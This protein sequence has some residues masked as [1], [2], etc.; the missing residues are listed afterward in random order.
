M[1]NNPLKS[2]IDGVPVGFKT[3]RRA[4]NKSVFILAHG[5]DPDL[6]IFVLFEPQ[7]AA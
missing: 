3:S 6:V 5:L 1:M 4:E 7:P 2:E